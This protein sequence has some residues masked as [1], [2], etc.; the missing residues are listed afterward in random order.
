MLETGCEEK[1]MIDKVRSADNRRTGPI[2][3]QL[4]P[5]LS[6][7]SRIRLTHL[8]TS[9]ALASYTYLAVRSKSA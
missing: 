8:Q 2:K 5:E 3:P 1:A 9:A 7:Q 6:T 4:H